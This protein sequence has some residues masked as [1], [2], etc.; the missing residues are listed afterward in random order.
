LV[1]G[2]LRILQTDNNDQNIRYNAKIER[3]LGAMERG[4]RP[5]ILASAGDDHPDVCGGVKLY[6]G[7]SYCSG[8]DLHS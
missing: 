3:Q 5:R 7:L 2:S 4:Y 6:A 8:V 1:T